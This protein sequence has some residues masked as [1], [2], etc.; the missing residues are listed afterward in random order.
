[1][2]AFQNDHNKAVT[3]HEKQNFNKRDQENVINRASLIL[4][5]V[6]TSLFYYFIFVL[7]DKN[8]TFVV[9]HTFREEIRHQRNLRGE[10][11]RA[12]NADVSSIGLIK[13][14]IEQPIEFLFKIRKPE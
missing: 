2:D 3:A 4:H 10:K 8:V 5:F 14:N 13:C 11:R 12:G 9:S 1:M 6:W 7:H